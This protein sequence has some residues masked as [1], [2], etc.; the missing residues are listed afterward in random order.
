MVNNRFILKG[1]T[2]NLLSNMRSNKIKMI[3]N[4]YPIES[5]N[6]HMSLRVSPG[7]SLI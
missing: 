3:T 1:S 7:M 6:Y 4:L 5:P 2:V